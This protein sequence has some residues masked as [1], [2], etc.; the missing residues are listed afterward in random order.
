VIQL[1][2]V[3]VGR[4]WISY[5]LRQGSIQ[6]VFRNLRSVQFDPLRPAGCNHDLVLQ[7]RVPGYQVDD[8][9][10]VAYHGDRLIYDGWDKQACLVP[11]E[12]WPLRRIFH[13]SNM[14]L[15]RF[16][17][18]HPEALQAVLTE[19]RERGPLIPKEFEFQEHRPEWKGSWYGPSLTKQ[20]LRALWH[21][22]LVMTHGRRGQH[23]VYDLTE[24]IVPA[25]L[26]AKPPLEEQEAVREL[27]LE[28]HRAVGILRLSPASEVWSMPC[29]A[30]IRKAAVA[31]LVACGALVEVEVDGM[32]AHAVPELLEHL[33]EPK[34]QRTVFLGPL[35]Q[36]MW[37][38]K[39]VFHVFGFDYIWEVYKPESERRWGYYSLPVLHGDRFIARFEPWV[40]GKAMTIRSWHWEP[41]VAPTPELIEAL[42]DA[43]HRFAIYAGAES[44]SGLPW[45]D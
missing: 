28:R 11:M 32:R 24:R 1:S 16:Q 44:V 3:D 15:A 13:A 18:D 38:R 40:R 33:D 35:D 23:H 10:T 37:D 21:G 36:L 29:S 5:S 17:R 20:A 2:K 39:M 30:A 34:P 8:W 6:E 14:S 12:G 25:D 19:L 7:A 9:R 42:T 43:A 4:A 45:S 22:G 41:D 31:Q 27:V 26:R